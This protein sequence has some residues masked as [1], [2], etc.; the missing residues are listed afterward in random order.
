MNDIN[1]ELSPER[2]AALLAALKARYERHMNRHPGLEWAAVQARLEAQPGKL[3]SL[4]EM[5][6][7]GGEPDVVGWDEQT[8]E[9]IFTDCSAESPAG[10]RNACYDREAQE[11]RKENRPADNALDMAAAM[12]IELLTEGQAR[13]RPVRRSPLR[14]RLRV[15]QRR[16]ILLQRP[17]IP[18]L[19]EGLKSTAGMQGTFGRKIIAGRLVES[20]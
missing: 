9:I 1:M 15:P 11:S 20:L 8:G 6:S 5:E 16:A 14:P 7:T 4:E 13:R 19:A 2:R 17:R 18:R 12:G 10:R 3:W